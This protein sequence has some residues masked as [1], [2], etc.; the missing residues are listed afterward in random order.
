[1]EDNECL[2][3]LKDKI[4]SLNTDYEDNSDALVKFQE[5]KLS[6]ELKKTRYKKYLN[7]YESYQNLLKK[8]L[9]SLQP[10]QYLKEEFQ[11]ILALDNNLDKL[12]TYLSEDFKKIKTYVSSK[13]HPATIEL[14]GVIKDI[15]NKL[16]IVDN[17]IDTLSSDDNISS[18][19]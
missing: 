4:K 10:I 2:E 7:Q 18:Q 16:E 9:E 11:D 15:E 14:K 8:D 19:P 1:M 6:L 17:Q 12:M 3:L 13:K 5:Q